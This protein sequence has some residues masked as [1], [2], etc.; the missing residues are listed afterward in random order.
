MASVVDTY[1]ENRERV[2]PD[3][4][5]NYETAHGGNVVRWMDEVGAISAMRHAGESC[6]TAHIDELD[7]ERPVPKGDTCVVE[8]YVYTAGRTSVRV[9]LQAYREAP[10]TGERE[11]TADS[12]FVFVAVDEDGE[13][14]EVPELTVESERG[15]KLRAAALENDPTE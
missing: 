14:T 8:S 3:D 1:F 11:R 4:T 10:R 6:L 5:N 13:P 15:R 9:R 2:Q 12:R 7:F